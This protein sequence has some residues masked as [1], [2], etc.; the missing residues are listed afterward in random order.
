M[1]QISLFGAAMG[2]EGVIEGDD[3]LNRGIW[4]TLQQLE[5]DYLTRIST[6]NNATSIALSELPTSNGSQH[7]F[8]LLMLKCSAIAEAL[9]SAN[10]T[11]KIVAWLGAVRK[12]Y[13]GRNF[14]YEDLLNVAHAHEV[15]VDPFLTDWIRTSKLPGFS[16]SPMVVTRMKDDEDGSPQY[17]T[18]VHVRNI[19]DTAGFIRLR[20]PTERTH[21]WSYPYLTSSN[22]IRVDAQSS[23][24]I[25][26]VT[27]Y[28]PSMV[29][30]D[31]GLSLNRNEIALSRSSSSIEERL[32]STP[33]PF[34]EDSSWN[35]AEEVG[36]IVD[37]LDPGFVVFQSNPNLKPSTRVGPLGWFNEPR[38]EG[39][40]DN[41]LPFYSGNFYLFEYYWKPGLWHRQNVESAFGKYRRTV[42]TV[43]LR[44]GLEAPLAVFG[45]QIPESGPWRLDY[46]FPNFGEGRWMENGVYDLN[47][48]DD[49]VA[50]PVSIKVSDLKRGWQ[51]IGMFDLNAG[52]VR[53]EFVGGSEIWLAILDAIR[54]TRAE[55]E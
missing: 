45:A 8:E 43:R 10:G 4:R 11:D 9:L 44:K 18:S 39:E 5:N 13:S 35:P 33:S 7:D 48:A 52:N 31:P 53:V 27:S 38:L 50:S 3:L 2:L 23:K 47:V 20:Y 19:E 12:Q 29:H 21:N 32:D 55:Q 15:S 37:D 51:E 46:H 34:E 24:K 49:I 54:W 6:W 25:N 26:L 41:G 40:L 16:I 42:A 28:E 17:Q 36:I 30:L 14:T 1:A 22:A